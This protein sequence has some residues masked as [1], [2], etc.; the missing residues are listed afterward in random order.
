MNDR[1]FRQFTILSYNFETTS[2]IKL[3]N[4]NLYNVISRFSYSSSKSFCHIFGK[5]AVYAL[6]LC[7]VLKKI[8]H[9]WWEE[10][11]KSPKIPKLLASISSF[12]LF[13]ECNRNPFCAL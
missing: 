10:D 11:Y 7:K 2:V 8:C 6:N 5:K 9:F 1:N 4:Y 13:L 12:E 3:H